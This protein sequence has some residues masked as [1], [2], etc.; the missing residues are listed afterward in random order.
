MLVVLIFSVFCQGMDYITMWLTL[1]VGCVVLPGGRLWC[2]PCC[3][4]LMMS[5]C[6]PGHFVLIT[7]ASRYLPS[8]VFSFLGARGNN[9]LVLSLASHSP[10]TPSR[11]AAQDYCSES[12]RDSAPPTYR[13]SLW[14]SASLY[15]R[16]SNRMTS[17]SS[18]GFTLLFRTIQPCEGLW[19]CLACLPWLHK[20]S[21][22]PPPPALCLLC[23]DWN[24][25]LFLPFSLRLF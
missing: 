15:S 16:V 6:V 21:S 14:Q 23:A 17:K 12:L 10:H 25:P 22:P 11:R 5:P 24:C 18:S 4:V 8:Q 2:S 20:A 9:F 1:R 13:K 3:P 7:N 19:Y